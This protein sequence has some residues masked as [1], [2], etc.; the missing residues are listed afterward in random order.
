MFLSD[1]SQIPH[2]SLANHFSIFA[3]PQNIPFPNIPKSIIITSEEDKSTIS[4]DQIHNI[5]QLVRTKQLHNLTIVIYHADQLT[6]AA[7]NC[8]LKL[9]EE[10]GKHIHFAFF[11]QHPQTILPTI[12]SRAH[13]YQLKSTVKISDPPI[14][15]PKTLDLAK[16]YLSASPR[17]L[18]TLSQTLAKDREKAL[19]VIDATIELAYKSYFKTKNPKFLD[20]L[21]SLL[22]THSA[23]TAN[24]HLR[25]Q[26]IA[27]L[28]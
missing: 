22:A 21:S 17:D 7:Q 25:L 26:L 9:L 28:L 2:I 24:G 8:F 16:S 15:D 11:T 23:L 13:S 3:F 12:H 18:I 27:H 4:I 20:K 10:P 5:E 1:I 6:D 14:I 19:F